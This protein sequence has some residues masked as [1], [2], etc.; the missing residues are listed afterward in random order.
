MEVI[1][2]VLGNI[3]DEEWKPRLKSARIDLLELSQWD[4]QKNRFRRR[5][6]EGRLAA[7]SLERGQ[8]L[9]DG[10]I[11]EWNEAE[12]RAIVCRIRL[13]PVMAVDMFGLTQLPREEALSSAVR[14]GHALG[15]QHWPAVVKNDVVYVPVSTGTDVAAS[16]MDTHD[17][18]G[19][20]YVFLA[21]EDVLDLLDEQ[22]A[23]RIFGGAECADSGC[24][25]HVHGGAGAFAGHAGQVGI[26]AETSGQE[27]GTHRYQ[28]HHHGLFYE[29]K[30]ST[31]EGE[32]VLSS[33]RVLSH[34]FGRDH[35]HGRA[36]GRLGGVEQVLSGEERHEPYGRGPH[37]RRHRGRRHRRNMEL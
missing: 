28:H 35:R 27:D 18:P 3:A 1:D 23:R 16:V 25:P 14:L 15:N 2:S 5:T 17:V 12:R 22:E 9:R 4:A 33:E 10:D 6:A 7:V 37:G 26:P 13:C 24:R 31:H 20:S 29:G 19:T 34:K 36:E 8:L 30:G 32:A 11:L 21:G